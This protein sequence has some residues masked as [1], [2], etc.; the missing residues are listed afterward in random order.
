MKHIFSPMM[1]DPF[2]VPMAP[3]P[4]PFHQH[5]PVRLDDFSPQRKFDSF[6]SRDAFT[7]NF[8]TRDATIAQA[9]LSQF[10]ISAAFVPRSRSTVSNHAPGPIPD[11]RSST[12]TSAASSFADEQRSCR[13]CCHSD[14]TGTIRLHGIRKQL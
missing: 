7:E 2:S 1:N 8:S 10:A 9:Y 4:P 11:A 12:S 3:P 6:R 5:N 14:S 13:T